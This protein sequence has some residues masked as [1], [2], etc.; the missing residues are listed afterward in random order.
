MTQDHK[1]LTTLVVGSILLYTGVSK[2]DNGR[3]SSAWSCKE[4]TASGLAPVFHGACCIGNRCD[5]QVRDIHAIQAGLRALVELGTRGRAEYLCADNQNALKAL[6]GGP[7][8]GREYVKECLKDV[9]TL[10]Q[11]GC[12]V[13][14]KWTR[15]HEGIPGNELADTLAK[16]ASKLTNHCPWEQS[17]HS[18]LRSDPHQPMRE[19]WQQRYNI[20]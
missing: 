12:K 18:W 13:R 1:W 5:I 6:V 4:A 15:S 3:T 2:T 9:N 10:Q 11:S 17:T 14:G 16:D 19:Q 20:G 8:T 7:T